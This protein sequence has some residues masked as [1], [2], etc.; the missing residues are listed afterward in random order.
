MCSACRP[1][2]LYIYVKF[3]EIS[4]TVSELW[5]WHKWWK[6]WWTDTQN[7][8]RYKIIS[9][10]LF[11]SLTKKKKKKKKKNRTRGLGPQYAYPSET[12]TADMQML[13]NIFQ[14]CRCNNWQGHHLRSYW[15]WQRRTCFFI[16]SFTLYVHDSHGM[17]PF[18]QTL[19]PVSTI[20]STR[21]LTKIGQ[22]VS[23][24]V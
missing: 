18:E 15:F 20:G 5:S 10:P 17:W 24:V 16:I 4:Q 1:V 22:V 19:N 23:K 12:A 6:S 2:M 21:N 14:S 3:C 9:S 8:L 11:T 7:F 13:C